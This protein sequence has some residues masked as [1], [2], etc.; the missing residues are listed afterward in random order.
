MAQRN[1]FTRFVMTWTAIA[2][3]LIV[4]G[5][6]LNIRYDSSGVLVALSLKRVKPTFADR[7]NAAYGF[8]P[9][10]GGQR[11]AKVLNAIWYKPQV[12]LFGSTV[13]DAFR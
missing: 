10:P 11:E 9:I 7:Y 3:A 12:A 1:T 5:L 13:H 8:Y 2:V 4:S 6:A